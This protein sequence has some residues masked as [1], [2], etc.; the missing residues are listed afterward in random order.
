M[1]SKVLTVG[2][3]LVVVDEVDA[4]AQCLLRGQLIADEARRRI[5]EDAGLPEVVWGLRAEDDSGS[6]GEHKSGCLD[7]VE[8]KGVDGLACCIRDACFRSGPW[9]V[10]AAVIG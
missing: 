10:G 3:G 5:D 7:D 1:T 9:A 8:D 4:G 6:L 2:C